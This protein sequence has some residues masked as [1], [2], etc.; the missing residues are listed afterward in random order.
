MST[1]TALITG[2]LIGAVVVDFLWA[3][4]FGIPQHFGYKIKRFVARIFR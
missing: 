3:W 2:I 1:T 4:K